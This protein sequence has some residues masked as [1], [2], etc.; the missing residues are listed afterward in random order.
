M[1]YDISQR[2][3]RIYSTLSKGHKK[4]ANVI[5]NYYD[6]AADL[7]AKK[8]GRLVGVSESTV[9]RFANVLGF[10]GYTDF[11]RAVQELVRIKLTPAQR[12]EMTKQR[13]GRGD[14]LENVLEADIAKIRYTI[15]KLNRDTFKKSVDAILSAKNI[16]VTGARSTEPIARL[17]SYNLSL[18]FD[19][20]K[21]V[22]PTSSAE[23]FEQ[24]FSIDENDTL[25][26]FSFPRYSS[27]MI[28]AAKYA[29]QNNAKVVVFTDSEVSPLSEYANFL[30]PAQ[31]DMASFMDSL[32]AP[33]SVINAIIVEITR[34]KEKEIV[35]RFD[36]LEKIW[37]E[38][39]V[40]AKR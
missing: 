39:H 23:V 4:I 27:K 8:L 28:N 34:R 35:Q 32:V 6:R 2:I 36:K 26:V 12:I 1:A 3:R 13:I 18:I 17:L 16:Y 9:V 31:S 24:M 29:R 37:D 5:L 15:E 11:Q 19:N 7:T 40:Y 30:I 25:I 22:I 33:L 10:E 14:I 38:Y 20:V 21:F